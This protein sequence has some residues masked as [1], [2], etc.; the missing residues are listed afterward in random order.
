MS[1]V[2][3]LEADISLLQ[4]TLDDYDVRGALVVGDRRSVVWDTLS[5]PRN[6]DPLVPLIGD[7]DLVIVY[8]H[9]DWDHIWGTAGLP[10]ARARIVG[11]ARCRERFESDAP[12]VLTEKQASAPGRWN[13]VVLVPPTETFASEWSVNLGGMNLV[14]HHLPGHTPDC[15]VGFIPERGVLFAGDT[16]ETPCPVVPVDSP[17]DSW[18]AELRRW[19]AD[20]RVRTVVPAHGPIGGRG[21]L[22]ENVTYLEGIL[23]SRP[24]DPRGPLTPFYRATHEQNL[25]WKAGAS[26]RSIT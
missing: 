12:L 22:E 1:D 23:S 4:V 18:I 13:D 17:L 11:H 9:A 20:A 24:I 25:Q 6:M 3:T 8:N 7:R 16:V 26:K 19:A 5:H 14:L 21:I 2:R 15:I 10:Y